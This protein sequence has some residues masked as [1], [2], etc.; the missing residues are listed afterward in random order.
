MKTVKDDNLSFLTQ[1]FLFRGSARLSVGVIAGFTLEE[2]PALLPEAVILGLIKDSLGKET[3]FDPGMPKPY[4]EALIAGKCFAP[5]GNPVPAMIPSFR[6]GQVRKRLAVFGNRC[7]NHPAG[8]QTVISEPEPFSE[9]EVTWKRAF[10]GPEYESNPEGMGMTGDPVPLPNVEFPDR[11]IGS[12]G[13]RPAPAGF[14]PLGMTW[15]GRLKGLG[16][17]DEAW[18]RNTWPAF[19]DDYNFLYYN[20]APA[21]QRIEG[22]FQG[23]EPVEADHLHPNRTCI[24]SRLPGIHARCFAV[25][26]EKGEEL[27]AE[28]E[29]RLETVWLIPNSLTGVLIWRG[30]TVVSDDEASN[31][32]LL[33]AFT[34][35]LDARP[36]SLEFYLARVRA[37]QAGDVPL[38]AAEAP[39]AEDIGAP[40]LPDLKAPKIPGVSAATAAVAGAAGAAGLAVS[41][42]AEEETG[43]PES[44]SPVAGPAAPP[45]AQETAAPPEAPSSEEMPQPVIATTP[46]EIPVIELPEF[47]PLEDMVGPTAFEKQTEA[48]LK[49]MLRIPPDQPFPTEPET[50]PEL[51]PKEAMSRMEAMAAQAEAEA[52]E[53]MKR[54]GFD[55]DAPVEI[56]QPPP[57][58]E[59]YLTIDPIPE[60]I[61]PEQIPLLLQEQSSIFRQRFDDLAK[62][63][64][65]DPY[66]LTHDEKPP[67]FSNA[68]EMEQYLK[69]SGYD[70]PD[71][72]EELR[73][74][75]TLQKEADRR[76]NQQLAVYGL[77]REAL[78]ADAEKEA[79][80]EQAREIA[81][82]VELQD[83]IR[84]L[85]AG[86][87]PGFSGD[88]DGLSGPGG[89][90]HA[91]MGSAAPSGEGDA[92]DFE[93]ELS[94]EDAA[95]PP[96]PPAREDILKRMEAGENLAGAALAGADL[97]ETN[98]S[99]RDF[100]GTDFS[101][102]NLEKADFN[103]SDLTGANLS[104]A[105]LTGAMFSEATLTKA[106]LSGVSASGANF[107][108]TNLSE[109]DLSNGDFTGAD[110]TGANLTGGKMDRALF[111]E[112]KMSH[113]ML[114]R[115][116]GLRAEF[117]GA[118]LTGANLS[119]AILT[120][121]DFSAAIIEKADFSGAD[122]AI[123]WF[124]KAR[125]AGSVFRT[126]NMR[127]C[128]ADQAADL[129]D[130]D[131]TGANQKD[132]RWQN[133]DFS[134]AHFGGADLTNAL[135][136][137][138]RF[139]K[140]DFTGVNAPNADFQKSALI[141]VR[142][143]R[144]NLFKGSLR[145][146]NL[147]E[148]DF[149][150]AN[151][152]GVDFYR[153]NASQTRFDDAILDGTLLAAWRPS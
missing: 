95:A 25:R 102:A 103:H 37:M 45:T 65:I 7:W 30:V 99:N 134:R 121:A 49:E 53:F 52:R 105:I 22:W 135:F 67:P 11:L 3:I 139:E 86:T 146:A 101:R 21:D 14:E 23:D 10:G 78:V 118:D 61:P 110:F 48:L 63:H 26:M 9:M 114:E 137:N 127:N 64:D 13:E 75:D 142:A 31:M 59:Q 73:K 124:S 38:A 150:G 12:P 29:M 32:P 81:K 89:V 94:G 4:G 28:I 33:S 111:N 57:E 148:T 5:N 79:V 60:N 54:N 91:G 43:A 87:V 97:S 50:I 74:I 69:K 117:M 108:G 143:T 138:C 36:E 1:V 16:T 151:L 107:A 68:A 120:E 76:I 6:V 93:G 136:V 153:A 144:M 129:T 119:R 51:S 106:V 147:A 133:T 20:R 98:L 44:V 80:E 72:F 128:R 126:A 116:S 70:N 39:K 109:A 17:F 34:E 15:P 131:F 113:A 19:P 40:G 140:A 84:Q 100:R 145:K 149:S 130:A 24:R 122:V 77:S 71:M 83:F 27:F 2:E 35:P 58:V 41:A 132:A 47:P 42:L 82:E 62:K 104:G 96:E 8:I 141:R 115:T 55:P 46:G 112:A 66:S 123:A 56:P 92:G 152:Y 85:A 18:V 90:S 88:T 125:G